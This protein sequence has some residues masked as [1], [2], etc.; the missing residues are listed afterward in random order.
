MTVE[1]YP[2]VNDKKHF[3]INIKAQAIER[4]ADDILQNLER[5]AVSSVS[6]CYSH[7]FFLLM[8]I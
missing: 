3:G 4:S 1:Q 7:P 8:S 5:C 2:R 6:I